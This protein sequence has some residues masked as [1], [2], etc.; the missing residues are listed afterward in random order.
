M[1]KWALSHECKDSY[2][3]GQDGDQELPVKTKQCMNGYD[4]E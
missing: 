3:E 2:E 1:T 4:T